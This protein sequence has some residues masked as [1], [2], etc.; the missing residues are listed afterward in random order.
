MLVKL[1]RRART[2]VW[3]AFSI[4]VILCAVVVGLGEILMPYSASYQGKLEDWLSREFGRPVEIESFTGEW[5]AFGPQLELKGLRLLSDDGSSATSVIE[6]AAIDVKPFN[7]LFP[8]RALYNFRVVGADFHLVRL[9]DGSFEFSGLGVGGGEGGGEGG[10]KQLASI[11][12]VILENSRLKID[13]EIHEVHLD[14]RD[15]NGRLQARGDELSVE[16]STS[17]TRRATGEVYGELEA[18]GKIL[19]DGDSQPLSA[20]WQFSGQELMLDELRDQ[21]PPSPY[22]PQQGRFNSELWGEWDRETQHRVRGA[23]DLRDVRLVN[24]HMDRSIVRLNTRFILELTDLHDWRLDLAELALDDGIEAFTIDSVA[25]GRHIPDEIGLWVS[26]DAVPVRLPA[27]IAVDVV[28]M[29]GKDWPHYIPASGTGT[30]E[31]FEMVL[32]PRMRLGSATGVFRQASVGDWGRWP[33]IRG[34]DGTLEFGP[35]WGELVING[36]DVDV[37]WPRMFN[38]PLTVDLPLCHVKFGWV[39]GVKG[40]YQVGIEQCSVE[41]EYVSGTGDMRFRGNTGKP[42]V[43]VV[44]YANRL[45]ASA[46][47][48]YWPRDLLKPKV[49]DWL[50]NGIRR[51]DLENGRLL[52]HGDMD[53]W[54]F[55]QGEGR[56]ETIANFRNAEIDYFEGW[57][58][59]NGVNGVV[60]FVNSGMDLTASIEDIAGVSAESVS[61]RISDFRNPEL[62]LEYASETDLPGVL[63]FIKQTPIHEKIEIDLDQFVFEG[64]TQTSGVLHVPL[65]EGSGGIRLDGKLDL[66]GNAFD[67]PEFDFALAGISGEVSYD[68]FGFHGQELAASF[69]DKPA[70]LEVRA[71]GSGP[72]NLT[73]Q[74]GEVSQTASP[75]GFYANLDGQ[76]EITD[77]LPE[78]FFEGWSSLSRIEGSSEWQ[79]RIS[80]GD[81]QVTTITLASELEGTTFGL[82]A[83]LNKSEDEKWPFEFELPVKE[84]ERTIRLSL[85]ERVSASFV[86][87]GAQDAPRQGSVAFGSEEPELPGPGLLRLGGHAELVNLDEWIDLVIEEAQ[88]GQNLGGLDIEPGLFTGREVI[89]VDRKFDE[90]DMTFSASDN[91]LSIQFDA[92]MIDGKVSFMGINDTSRSLNAEFE[93]LVLDAPMSTGMQMDVDPSGLPDLHL[94][95]QS[96]SYSG[97]E[98][99]ATR[100]EAYPTADGFRFEKVEAESENMNLRA[101]GDWSL[102]ESGHRSNFNID[103]ASESLGDFLRHLGIAT[104]VEGG[105]TLVHFEVWWDGSPGQ[106]QL[107]RLNGD[108]N[109]NVNT[110]VIRDASPGTGRL[111]GLLSV[112]ALPRRLALDFRDVFDSGFVFDEANGSFEMLN[113]SAR[114]DDVLLKSSAANISFSGT[115]DLVAQEYD[116]LI[117]VR[118]GLGNTLPVIGAIA[119]GPTG[120]AAGLALQGLLHRELGEAS[121]VQYTL[122]GAW[123]EP[124]IEP[125]IETEADG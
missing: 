65:R 119:G 46:A 27:A 50:S 34:V 79:A 121:Q 73:D 62:E 49:I 102:D 113:G 37:E 28:R 1:M 106:F 55:D 101:S 105:Q 71:Q 77:L 114:T 67:A 82:P 118:P 74:A 11:N 51:G 87:V 12:E 104:P 89:F 23:L 45:D 14:F 86:M 64:A 3:T 44:V 63:A 6:E 122:T 9:E 99:G 116:Q 98:L 36:T 92:E 13:D 91:G 81:G 93:R 68:E 2:L 95:A 96:M 117:T 123:T 60:H 7:V 88:E 59:A 52:I 54:P 24:A 125:V 76:F 83:P 94:F 40:Q 107:A 4:I 41:N 48:D 53:D 16:I 8:S 20:S 100:I 32:N 69:R 115:T 26:T 22:F 10:L 15:I 80:A 17:L 61:A 21:F 58:Q 66:D 72:E 39:P 70:R 120:A 18:T 25:L 111:L 110:G 112:Q 33:D 78:R 57:P 42:S 108:V 90:V 19:M 85:P 47:G 43:D 30:V 124:E 75:S 31:S 97:I 109:F 5:K 103:M 35:G 84:G 38:A 29:V 56:F